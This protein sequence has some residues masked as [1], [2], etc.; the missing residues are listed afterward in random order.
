M[1]IRYSGTAYTFRPVPGVGNF[2]GGVSHDSDIIVGLSSSLVSQTYVSGTN[3]WDVLGNAWMKSSSDA[4][5][6]KQIYITNTGSSDGVGGT[7]YIIPESMPGYTDERQAY[8][9]SNS[10]GLL[11]IL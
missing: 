1:P 6:N 10:N 8:D 7:W 11:Q 9:G 4:A 2:C 5:C 3:L